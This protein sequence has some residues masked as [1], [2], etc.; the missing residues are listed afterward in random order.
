MDCSLDII[1]LIADIYHIYF[2]G[3]VSPP[4]ESYFSSGSI[5]L[6]MNFMISLF[7]TAKYFSIVQMFHIFHMHTFVKV[8]L[9]CFQF[10]ATMNRKAMN[11]V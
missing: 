7:L 6:T 1:D 2:S 5:Y 3:S 11:V 4:S 8:Y 10:L 9:G